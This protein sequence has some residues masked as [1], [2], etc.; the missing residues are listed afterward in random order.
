MMLAA[1]SRNVPTMNQAV[2]ERLR[3]AADI[4]EEQAGD[5]FRIRAY[6]RA[7]DTVTTLPGDIAALLA[8]EGRQGLEALPTLG[9]RI[10][11]AVRQLVTIGRWG[12]L[13]RLRR[14]GTPAARFRR[15]PGIGAAL[16]ARLHQTL[17]VATLEALE[18]AAHDGR[19]AAVP[20]VGPRRASII[21]AGLAALLGRPARCV[22]AAPEPDVATLLDVDREYRE[23]A[24][25]GRLRRIAPRR[26]NPA[27]AAWLPVLHTR[28]GP[29]RITALFSNT[30]RAHQAHRTRDW[31]VL[32]FRSDTGVAEGWRTV[33]TET[34]GPLEGRRVVRGREHE[35][36]VATPDRAAAP[37]PTP[38][39][40]QQG[41]T[42]CT[43]TS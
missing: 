32:F 34:H 33:V 42:P 7:A 2:A 9:P 27:G 30:A 1:S 39:A 28:R 19:L 12:E 16:A 5:R 14:T 35:L 24:A 13:E 4:L 38:H 17:S 8:R 20:G 31:V 25:T 6:R 10:A 23:K 22:G 41:G 3:E 11:D 43:G 29:W 36:A 21:R 18:I 40:V 26:F 37:T 15:V